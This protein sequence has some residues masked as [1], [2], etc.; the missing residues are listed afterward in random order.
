MT[1]P[2]TTEGCGGTKRGLHALG[3]VRL[4]PQ[5]EA[6]LDLAA[7]TSG[8]TSAWRRRKRRELGELLALEQAAPGRL[9]VGAVELESDLC[10]V[11]RMQV[12]V[13]CRSGEGI[14][15]RDSAVL[16]L[17]YPE[18]ALRRPL[19]G[20]AFIQ[21]LMPRNV[22]LPCVR[23]PEQPLC[24]GVALGPGI[25]VRSLVLLAYGALSMQTVQVDETDSAG[26]FNVDAA[27]FWQRQENLARTPLSRTPFL[28]PEAYP[29]RPVNR[30][31]S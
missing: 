17:R 13:P 7:Q 15:V 23:L 3:S 12:P 8:G 26:V 27:R 24:L 2:K 5:R 4:T 22:W 11:L 31:S 16:G 30:R 29:E 6:R 9:K 18:E 21:I 1:S 20:A 28:A 19:P 10:V 14:E 25:L